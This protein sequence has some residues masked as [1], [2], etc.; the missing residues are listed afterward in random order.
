LRTRHGM[1]AIPEF[2]NLLTNG[3]HLFFGGLRLHDN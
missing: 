1:R 3:A 2:L